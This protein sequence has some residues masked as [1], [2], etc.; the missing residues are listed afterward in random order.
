MYPGRLPPPTRIHALWAHRNA[1]RIGIQAPYVPPKIS[2]QSFHLHI[3]LKQP[4]C[5]AI[6]SHTICVKGDRMRL[7]IGLIW[8]FMGVLCFWKMETVYESDKRKRNLLGTFFFIFGVIGC[9]GYVLDSD[10]LT[11]A[12]LVLS[13]SLL[14]IW[15]TVNMVIRVIS[16]RT[17]ILAEYVRYNVYSGGKGQRSYSPVFRYYY[18]GN[19]YERQTPEALSRKRI[20]R[21]FRIGENYEIYIN[22]NKPECCVSRRK[23]PPICLITGILGIVFLIFYLFILF[24]TI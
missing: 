1:L 19:A 13:T 2:S 4:R 3:K 11:L 22:S 8:I 12:A 21:N 15:V 5:F 23:I 24:Q 9:L 17:L 14:C 16:C 10:L 18:Q 7:F 6:T 20:E